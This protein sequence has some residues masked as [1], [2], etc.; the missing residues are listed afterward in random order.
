MTSLDLSVIIQ[1]KQQYNICQHYIF[2]TT[3]LS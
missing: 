2:A 1:G 3:I